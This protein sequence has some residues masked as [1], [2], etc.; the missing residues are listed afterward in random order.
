MREHDSSVK[1]SRGNFSMIPNALIEDEE[2]KPAARFTY[3]LLYSKPNDWKFYRKNLAKSLSI[4]LE[5]LDKYLSI[6]EEKGWLKRNQQKNERGQFCGLEIE[7]FDAV[8]EKTPNGTDREKTRYGKNRERKNPQHSNTNPTNTN[9]NTNTDLSDFEKKSQTEILELET[10]EVFEQEKEGKR[11]VAPK[12]K[13]LD[14]FGFNESTL[15][16][17]FQDFWDLYDK[18]TGRDK[19][20]KKWGRLK[21]SEKEKIMAHIPDYVA[22]QPDKTYRKNPETYLNGKHWNDEVI[23]KGKKI[24][25]VNQARTPEG[26]TDLLNYVMS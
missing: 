16:P 8:T 14:L 12:E 20:E 23:F 10:E 9:L 19:T 15:W 1:K 7:L 17:S 24:D 4:N 22:S 6:L 21:Q 3:V 25:A 5:T 13:E 2:I 11:K 26:F 18:K